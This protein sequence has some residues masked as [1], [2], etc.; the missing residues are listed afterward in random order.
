M[1]RANLEGR[2]SVTR[3]VVKEARTADF[4]GA[5]GDNRLDPAWWGWE[6]DNGE[7]C[8]LMPNDSCDYIRI[9]HKEARR[10]RDFITAN[11]P[12]RPKRKETK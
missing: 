7:W 5:A 12:A 6:D 4:F 11:L 8:S 9:D 1:V 3:R 10:L 2:K